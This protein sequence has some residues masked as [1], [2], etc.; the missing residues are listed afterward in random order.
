MYANFKN[1]EPECM[2]ISKTWRLDVLK[3]QKLGGWVYANLKDM[4]PGCMLISKTWM[5]DV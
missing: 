1:M 4:E 2:L 3:F 5:P